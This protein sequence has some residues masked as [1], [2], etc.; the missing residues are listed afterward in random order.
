MLLRL[1]DCCTFV[2]KITIKFVINDPGQYYL[3]EYNLFS[4]YR[5]RVIGH[6]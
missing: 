1:K 4:A 3:P 2:G 6:H 5:F